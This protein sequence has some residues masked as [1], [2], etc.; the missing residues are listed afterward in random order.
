MVI[1][2]GYVYYQN[3]YHSDRTTDEYSNI[4][5]NYENVTL[6]Y[7]GI[8]SSP[9]ASHNMIEVEIPEGVSSLEIALILEEK[10]LISAENFLKLVDMFALEKEIKAGTYTFSGEVS[11]IDIIDTIM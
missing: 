9:D 7:T 10:N 3:Q 4:S 6:D 2:G 8:E 5:Y 11:F 1:L